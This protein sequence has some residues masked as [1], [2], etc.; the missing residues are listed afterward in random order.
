VA[1][2]NGEFVFTEEATNNFPGGAD[3]LYSLMNRLD[4]ESETPQEAR[5]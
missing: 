1:L 3:G 2:S 4:P 5:A